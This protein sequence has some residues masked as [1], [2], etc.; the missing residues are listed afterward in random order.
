MPSDGLGR[1]Q[2]RGDYGTKWRPFACLRSGERELCIEGI[3]ALPEF[4]NSMLA[5]VVNFLIINPH[6]RLCGLAA[7]RD[8][9]LPR[10][11]VH[12]M[13]SN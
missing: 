13:L 9:L 1:L 10:V 12:F 6:G 3:A 11:V 5:P 8:F 4:T 7:G 2:Q